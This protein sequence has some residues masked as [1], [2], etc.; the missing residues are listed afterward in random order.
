MFA[1][2]G[3]AA[4]HSDV[5]NSA[6]RH[7]RLLPL[8]AVRR[9]GPHACEPER[10]QLVSPGRAAVLFVRVLHLVRRPALALIVSGIPSEHNAILVN[11]C[12]QAFG[13]EGY[14]WIKRFAHGQEIFLRLRRCNDGLSPDG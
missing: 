11:G 2:V 7:G 5:L 1:G 13:H 6:V 9:Q 10:L 8:V 14:G 3:L 12:G 4:L